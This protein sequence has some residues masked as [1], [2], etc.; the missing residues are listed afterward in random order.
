MSKMKNI[1]RLLAIIAFAGLAGCTTIVR[2]N[3]QVWHP[4]WHVPGHCAGYHCRI[5][6]H[7][8]HH[9]GYWA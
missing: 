8:Y 6:V 5:W 1:S 7:G 4:G 9:H 3:G 2:P